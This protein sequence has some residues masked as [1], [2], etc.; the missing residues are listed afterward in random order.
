MTPNA[1]PGD[2]NLAAVLADLQPVAAQVFE[3]IEEMRRKVYESADY[4]EGINAFFDKRK[5]QFRGV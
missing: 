2:M 5:P 3:R 1:R 4:E